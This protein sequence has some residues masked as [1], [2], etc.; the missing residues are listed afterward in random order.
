MRHLIF[1]ERAEQE[2][3]PNVARLFRAVAY[4]KQ[5]HATNHYSVLGVIR[6][7]A[8]NLQ[9]AINGETYEGSEMYPAY[10]AVAELQEEKEKGKRS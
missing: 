3:F 8:D 5:M 10:E 9:V 2:G 6:R 1:A 7:T 4:A